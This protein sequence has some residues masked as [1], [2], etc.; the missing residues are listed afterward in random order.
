MNTRC[1]DSSHRVNKPR[2]ALYVLS[3]LVLLAIV[4][5]A[6]I[7]SD[8]VEFCAVSVRLDGQDTVVATSTQDW[9]SGCIYQLA[10]RLGQSAVLCCD[11]NDHH[12]DC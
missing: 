7:A 12:A 9:D 6:D 2:A 4:A 8:P 3:S 5:V 1:Q 11:F 10:L